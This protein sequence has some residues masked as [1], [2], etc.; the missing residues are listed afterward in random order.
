MAERAEFGLRAV[1]RSPQVLSRRPA[2]IG[3]LCASVSPQRILGPD[4]LAE[5]VVLK[6]NVL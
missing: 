3:L 4:G 2:V 1:N 6:S 5:R